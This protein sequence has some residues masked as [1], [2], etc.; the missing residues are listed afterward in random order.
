MS[1]LGE[2]LVGAGLLTVEQVEQALRA[3]VMWGGRLG[4]NIIELGYLDLDKLAVALGS[5]HAL[6]AALGRHFDQSEPALQRLLSAE[7]AE[8]FACVPLLRAGP[9]KAQV[10][11]ASIGPL[12]KKALAIVADELALDPKD[13]VQSVAGELRVRYHLER[14]YKIPR[15]ARFL[16]PRGKTIPPF[17]QFDIDPLAFEDSQVDNPIVTFKPVAAPVAAPV[18]GVTIDPLDPPAVPR[19]STRP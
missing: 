14:V 2:L 8:R 10:I 3:Q 7:F 15:G 9:G 18:P 19:T 6:P 17:P 13:I 1:R 11:V 12:E 5:L 4:T 16:R